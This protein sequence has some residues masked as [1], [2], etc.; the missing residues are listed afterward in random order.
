M[1][2]NRYDP[3]P[4]P[5]PSIPKPVDKKS[6]RQSLLIAFL[7]VLVVGAIVVVALLLIE[8]RKAQQTLEQLA[9]QPNQSPVIPLPVATATPT[10]EIILPSSSIQALQVAYFDERLGYNDYT[11]TGKDY[12]VW[13]FDANSASPKP[14][15]VDK[16]EK[17]NERLNIKSF[18]DVGVLFSIGSSSEGGKDLGNNQLYVYG[19]TE[20]NVHN[21]QGLTDISLSKG[22]IYL[23]MAGKTEIAHVLFP[24]HKNALAKL[25]GGSG[26]FVTA[27]YSVTFWCISEDCQLEYGDELKTLRQGQIRVFNSSKGKFSDAENYQPPSNRY[28][29]FISWNN[30]C[31][32]CIPF[33][34][35]PTPTP[36]SETITT[37]V[38]A[39]SL[40]KTVQPTGSGKY[41]LTVL[42]DGQG[43]VSPNWGTYD[44]GTS[45]TL[46]ASPASGWQF[47][48][49]DIGGSNP[50]ITVVMNSNMT[51]TARFT[52]SGS[53]RY[54]LTVNIDGQGS[55]TPNGGSYEAGT[56]VT[57][58]ASP[59]AGWEFASWS[60]GGSS[61]TTTIVMD[62]NKTVTARFTKK[63]TN[64]YTLTVN[65][66]GQGSVSPNGGTYDAGTRVTLTATPASGWQ[67]ASWSTGGSSPTTTIVMDGNKT[68]TARFTKK[69]TAKYTLSV[70]VTGS[71]TVSPNGGSY[72]A[73]TVVTLTATPS[74]GW[75]FTKWS[76]GETSPVI[77]VTMNGDKLIGALFT[78]N[79]P[80]PRYSL[81]VFIEGQG[82][83]SPNG[84]SY[85][86]GTAVVLTA[87]P[88]PG[89][90]F[91][92]WSTGDTS[93]P[94]TVVMDRN[95]QIRATFVKLSTYNDLRHGFLL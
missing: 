30:K 45:V 54:T 14:I 41:T 42:I 1:K 55:V 26:L 95:L 75:T 2:S 70:T 57:L 59:A 63:M 94:L 44:A 93:N 3:T 49:W 10:P 65:I 40:T 21:Q 48:G 4:P 24:E 74:A 34:P 92:N 18:G 7:S 82:S 28:E 85:E 88:A 66:D 58:T 16:V 46:T 38:T 17:L 15:D 8:N 53:A 39:T 29:E 72:D 69:S 22:A 36:V 80:T 71:G 25:T 68:V 51:I 33:D 37:T 91:S 31:N 84:G 35:V 32:Q 27:K 90:A 81:T 23:K 43:S 87:S 62:G 77:S 89:W 12:P 19:S 76:T 56:R 78:E 60:T 73:G 61:P 67:F 86:A 83:V 20:L 50:T 11:R 13:Y 5:R 79:T 6:V 64:R 52:T 47:A 9:A